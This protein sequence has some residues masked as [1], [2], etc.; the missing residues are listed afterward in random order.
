MSLISEALR[1][2]RQEAARQEALKSGSAYPFLVEP[3]PDR[4]KT[5]NYLIFGLLAVLLAAGLGAAGAVWLMSGRVEVERAGRTAA[6]EVV[7]EAPPAEPVTVIEETPGSLPAGPE[8]PQADVPEPEPLPEAAD[9]EPSPSQISSEPPARPVAPPADP[10]LTERPIQLREPAPPAE[11][12][13]SDP[14][15]P[16][17]VPVQP[18]PAAPAPATAQT[19]QPSGPTEAA[20]AAGL[21]NG[22]TFVRE[23]PVPGGGTLRLNGIAF[24]ENPVALFTD[25]VVAP[26][27]EV[28]GFKVSK[29]E[30]GR[31]ELQGHGVTV[32]VTV[33]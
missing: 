26:G 23:I 20:V 22:K 25:K 12:P 11:A 14:V 4:G 10:R 1:K 31:V 6:S 9:P 27:E 5:R 2:A 18:A 29:V 21:E 30:A 19:P 8:V 28:Q 16:A 3:A 7:A 17:P 32:Y 15:L 24:S 13:V 33:K